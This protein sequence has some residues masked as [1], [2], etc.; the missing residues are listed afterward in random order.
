M[1]AKQNVHIKKLLLTLGTP[2]S[3][4]KESPYLM[5]LLAFVGRFMQDKCDKCDACD[6][7]V[8]TVQ[9]LHLGRRAVM[10]LQISQH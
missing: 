2:Q 9:R 1:F 10:S 5:V 8:L 6:T 3:L 7:H 4:F